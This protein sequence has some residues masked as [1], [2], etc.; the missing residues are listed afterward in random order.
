MGGRSRRAMDSG[1][2]WRNYTERRFR[3]RFT[4]PVCRRTSTQSAERGEQQ[5]RGDAHGLERNALGGELAGEHDRHVGEQHAERR[6]D[7]HRGERRRSCAASTTVATC[8]LSPISARKNA[9]TVTPNT[10][11]L[12]RRRLASSSSLSGFS[13]HAR[14]GEER[15][16]E[17]PAQ[18]VG[19]NCARE[20]SC[21]RGRRA[22][23]STSVATRM[24]AMIGHG[25][26]NAGGEHQREELRLV[27]DL[28]Q[29]DHGRP[30][31]GRLPSG[32]SHCSDASRLRAA[33]RARHAA[34]RC[35]GTARN[36]GEWDNA[37]C[38][39]QER[40]AA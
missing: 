5:R 25:L 10:P 30:R 12:R 11:Q 15:Q 21:R 28:A 40:R 3:A 9:T 2:L 32:G 33:R 24:P 17:Q 6:A 37:D 38:A 16:R 20:P 34:G 39:R 35:R 36:G 19:G 4:S 22:R 7:D 26:R 27:A 31:R 13:A 1:R 14:D 8:V 23:G 18:H 29:R